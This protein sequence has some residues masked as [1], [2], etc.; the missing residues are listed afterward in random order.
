MVPVSVSIPLPTLVRLPVPAIE[1]LKVPL[2]ALPTSML[3]APRLTVPLPTSV[4]NTC[5]PLPAD[6]SSVAPVARLTVPPAARLAPA[7]SASVPALTLVP[8]V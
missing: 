2:A 4:P 8:P 7:P 1:P 3:L 5:V 6:R